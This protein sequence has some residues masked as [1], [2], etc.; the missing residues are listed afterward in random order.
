[1]CI[2][3]RWQ[4]EL[5]RSEQQHDLFVVVFISRTYTSSSIHF[6]SLWV[7][8]VGMPPFV[9]CYL[10]SRQISWCKQAKRTMVSAN[11]HRI[12]V[13]DDD[14]NETK[15]NKDTNNSQ[16]V[17][18][19]SPKCKILDSAQLRTTTTAAKVMTSQVVAKN[20][21]FACKLQENQIWVLS[22]RLSLSLLRVDDV[23][24][25]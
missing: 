11:E 20:K 14:E 7:E 6:T 17:V 10:E 23:N 19:F 24:R 15:Q 9:L 5:T 22:G 2:A 25:K 13:D 18:S 21:S 4:G 1:M 16:N 12:Q 3:R 8:V